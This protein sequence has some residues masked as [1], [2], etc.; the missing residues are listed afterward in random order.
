[1][2]YETLS[3]TKSI[4]CI[5]NAASIALGVGMSRSKSDTS[6]TSYNNSTL[7]AQSGTIKIN[8]LNDTGIKGANLLGQNIVLNTAGNL[9]VESL[10]NSYN[11][12]SKSFGINLGGGAGASGGGSANL[13][14]NYSSAKTDRLW[15]DNQTTILGTNSVTINTGN[16]TAIAGAVIANS[17]NGKIGANAIDGGNLALNTNTLTFA[18]LYDHDYSQSSGFGISTSIGIG[19]GNNSSGAANNTTGQGTAP[20]TN[21]GQQNNFYPSGSTTISAQNQGYKKEGT[22]FASVGQ[23]NIKT[24]GAQ[25]FDSTT[26]NLISNTSG[27]VLA[28]NSAAIQSLNRDINKTQ[29]VTRDTITGALDTSITIDNRILAAA[30]GSDV[31]WNS[32]KSDQ[33]NLGKNLKIATREQLKLVA[34]VPV[35]PMFVNKNIESSRGGAPQSAAWGAPAVYKSGTEANGVRD[36]KAN[37]VG[38]GNVPKDQD[39][40]ILWDKVGTEVKFDLTTRKG[41]MD[42][43]GHEGGLV[44]NVCN[45]GLPG[46]NDMS[47]THDNWGNSKIVKVI[48]LGLQLSIIPAYPYNVYGLIGKPVNMLIDYLDQSDQTN[49]SA[50]ISVSISTINSNS[51]HQ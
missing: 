1:M 35:S 36:P 40:N 34:A 50:P 20:A 13:G 10:Q 49:N 46:C 42:W 23:G 45:Y 24:G 8:T 32:L 47:L 21:P 39:G 22:T 43:L 44:S 15:T 37:N 3:E 29:I 30:F 18:N 48:P 33:E 16:N 19:G 41:F 2:I 38:L 4:I 9:T 7:N 51:K 25:M 11:N 17:T 31:A 5:V 27:T 28:S 14:V 12:K 6:S 26:G